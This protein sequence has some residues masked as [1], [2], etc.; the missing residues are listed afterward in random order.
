MF[1]KREVL[2]NCSDMSRP[3][4]VELLLLLLSNHSHNLKLQEK[5]SR[6]PEDS[7]VGQPIL[8]AR[9]TRRHNKMLING[10][11]PDFHKHLELSIRR[12][13]GPVCSM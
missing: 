12:R 6:W 11:L 5:A 10:N 4:L 8:C 13:F 2:I 9:V 1:Y 7:D 3:S